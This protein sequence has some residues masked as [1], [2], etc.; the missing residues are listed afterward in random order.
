[1]SSI[2]TSGAASVVQV[3]GVQVSA[4]QDRDRERG[5]TDVRR[6]RRSADSVELR[7][8]ETDTDMTLRRLPPN[9]SEQAGEEHDRR[10]SG[11]SADHPNPA[12]RPR[13]DLHA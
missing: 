4:A 10:G 7:V 2:P 9:E 5:R 1:M 8:H 3:A 12:G 13:I 6:T 11:G